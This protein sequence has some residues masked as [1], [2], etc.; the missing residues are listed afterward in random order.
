M[1][2][3]V[4]KREIFVTFR[5][6]ALPAQLLPGPL[7]LGMSAAWPGWGEAGASWKLVWPSPFLRA[8]VAISV[9]WLNMHHVKP[10]VR[11]GQNKVS[12]RFGWRHRTHEN[13][14]HVFLCF[15]LCVELCVG[16]VSARG[17]ALHTRCRG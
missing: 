2:M 15:Y 12:S 13:T 5:V 11:F 8:A 3:P 16:I 6:G 17:T 4:G 10:C 14:E 1:R 7:P 9:A